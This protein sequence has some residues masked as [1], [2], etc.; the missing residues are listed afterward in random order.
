VPA[1]RLDY[2]VTRGQWRRAGRGAGRRGSGAGGA[3]GAAG[4]AAAD[5]VEIVKDPALK[6][7][8]DGLDDVERTV[9]PP[10]VSLT[11]AKAADSAP[12]PPPGV[13]KSKSFLSLMIGGRKGGGGG[14]DD[15]AIVPLPM[16]PKGNSAV[17]S[18][19]TLSPREG[20]AEAQGEAAGSSSAEAAAAVPGSGEAPSSADSLSLPSSG[21][22]SWDLFSRARKDKVAVEAAA[23]PRTIV[24][25]AETEKDRD[26]WLKRIR[27]AMLGRQAVKEALQLAAQGLAD[28]SDEDWGG[29]LSLQALLD[30]VVAADAGGAYAELAAGSIDFDCL[31]TDLAVL[32]PALK[33]CAHL[34]EL[35]L[36][37]RSLA[38]GSLS[39]DAAACLSDVFK[40]NTTLTA[41]AV[42]NHGITDKGASVLVESAAAHMR[43][44]QL[45]L[46]RCCLMTQEGL[47]AVY[48]KLETLENSRFNL[49][50]PERALAY[51][52][53]VGRVPAPLKEA[54]AL[55][56][57]TLVWPREIACHGCGTHE[58][59][60]PSTHGLQSMD[61]I[62]RLIET[63][64][65]QGFEFARPGQV[66][67]GGGRFQF[68]LVQHRNGPCGVLAAVQAEILRYL[69]W[70]E[71]EEDENVDEMDWDTLDQEVLDQVSAKGLVT[72]LSSI[73]W[74][75][76]PDKDASVK[77]VLADSLAHPLD[78]PSLQVIE[79]SSK[80][81]VEALVRCVLKML[82][83]PGGV[84]LLL[85]SVVMTRGVHKVWEEAG[86]TAKLTPSMQQEEEMAVFQTL[87]VME[88][89][90]PFCEQS[91]VNLFLT[92][93]ASADLDPKDDCAIGFLTYTENLRPSD[94]MSGAPWSD[95]TVVGPKYKTPT[96]PIWV[97]HGGSHYT[98]LMARSKGLLKLP[99]PNNA[100]TKDNAESHRIRRHR[101]VPSG[102]MEGEFVLEH[103]NGLPPGGPRLVKLFMSFNLNECGGVTEDTDEERRRW[104]ID[105]SSTDDRVPSDKNVPWGSRGDDRPKKR[106]VHL[107]AVWV[108]AM[109]TTVEAGVLKDATSCA[110]NTGPRLVQAHDVA[111]LVQVSPLPF[112]AESF[113]TW[114]DRKWT[115]TGQPAQ[116][117]QQCRPCPLER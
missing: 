88:G 11:D 68:G 33:R 78:Y 62:D 4:A 50:V 1:C 47:Q 32:V 90:W 37:C 115:G 69:V 100:A 81:Q 109:P 29:R 96:T 52:E 101:R 14:K 20:E 117:A 39:D 112:P 23:G 103:Y 113:K 53:L 44:T 18:P 2:H 105:Y 21:S 45:N 106:A 26:A 54:D 7:C 38:C 85:Y 16:S 57:H 97:L 9:S 80:P 5:G 107:S 28:G 63:W 111:E 86:N 43:A 71:M 102:G 25:Q 75:A 114:P 104:S 42:V 91:L 36:T 95:P 84:I 98:V 93:Q 108:Q 77:V 51:R 59:L 83:N 19:Q 87:V 65:K 89:G 110:V 76:R 79:C 12:P 58:L 10:L 99:D 6:D 34:R 41:L 15:P 35:D 48:R 49:Q 30:K 66:R 22:S 8:D 73:L 60:G 64:H 72:A 70:P 13:A 27:R 74:R 56:L 116:A 67:G 31:D 17:A 3:A 92:G 24:L 82:V 40:A 94:V 55:M 46:D 61:V